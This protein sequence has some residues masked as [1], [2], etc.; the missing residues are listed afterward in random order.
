MGRLR[1]TA[2]K[3]PRLPR[4]AGDLFVEHPVMAEFYASEKATRVERRE[5]TVG[6]GARRRR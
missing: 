2:P 1:V 6:W 4:C 3:L 5:L